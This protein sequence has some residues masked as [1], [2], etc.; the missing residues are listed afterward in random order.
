MKVWEG[1]RREGGREGNGK[2]RREGGRDGNVGGRKGGEDVWEEESEGRKERT[3]KKKKKVEE[4]EGGKKG[5]VQR[6]E[7][8]KEDE[9]E[10]IS[11]RGN[12][13]Q[14]FWKSLEKATVI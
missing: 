7:N 6:E 5:G 10:R 9:G 3:K 1:R 2:C 12:I 11:V 8:V 13:T 14:N 4:E